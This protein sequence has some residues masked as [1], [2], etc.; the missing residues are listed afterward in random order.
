MQ[1]GKSKKNTD[2]YKGLYL[3]YCR[4][5]EVAFP[6]VT[7]VLGL[8][9][10]HQTRERMSAPPPSAPRWRRTGPEPLA[11][12]TLFLPNPSLFKWTRSMC[13]TSSAL[14]TLVLSWRHFRS[15]PGAFVLNRA[16]AICCVSQAVWGSN[17]I[18]N[19]YRPF[20]TT[21]STETQFNKQAQ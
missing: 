18:I 3:Y 19:K 11:A 1:I 8:N 5:P 9:S 10:V 6:T 21:K 7:A 14:D 13:L 4:L 16:I 2:I 20:L 17:T 15:L 12:Y